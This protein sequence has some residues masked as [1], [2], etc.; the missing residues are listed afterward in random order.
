MNEGDGKIGGCRDG[1]NHGTITEIIAQ[2]LFDTKKG[3]EGI[4]LLTKPRGFWFAI[5]IIGGHLA[6]GGDR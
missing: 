5:F 1:L 2:I 3:R 4:N 6:S